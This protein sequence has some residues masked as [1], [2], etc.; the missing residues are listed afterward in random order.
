MAK[1]KVKLLVGREG[2][3]VSQ[4]P[5][6][7]IEVDDKEAERMVEAGQCELVKGRKG[8]ETTSVD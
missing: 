6:D 3:E 2:P 7:V 8:K 5:G 4:T 1:V